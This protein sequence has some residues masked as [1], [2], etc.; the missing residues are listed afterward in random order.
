VIQ[1]P[2]STVVLG[3]K[4]SPHESLGGAL[5]IQ[6]I[7]QIFNGNMPFLLPEGRVEREQAGN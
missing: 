2:L 7:T 5:P 1:S 3:T 4:H 6:T